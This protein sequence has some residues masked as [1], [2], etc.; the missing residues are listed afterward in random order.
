MTDIIKTNLSEAEPK[1]IADKIIE[2][3]EDKLAANV[4]LLEVGKKTSV[5]DYFVICSATST[6]QVKALADEAEVKLT[7][8]GVSPTRVDGA[9]G[10]DWIV[11]DF[12]TVILHVF[13]KTAREF[14]KLD[15]LWTDASKVKEGE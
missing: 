2:V 3:L 6:T 13:T 9:A 5:A 14:Y 7:E 10:G 15:K 4:Q 12:N 1:Q 8:C 11:L